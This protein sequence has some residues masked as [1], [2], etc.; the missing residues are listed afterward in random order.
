MPRCSNASVFCRISSVSRPRTREITAN[1]WGFARFAYLDSPLPSLFKER[2]F[3]YLSRFCE[4]RYCIVRHLGFLV[5]LGRPSGDEH[6]V[7]Q[8]VEEAL[9]L[10][11]RRLARGKDAEPHISRCAAVDAPLAE[12]PPPDSELEESIFTCAAHAF[13]QTPDAPQCLA[14]LKRAFGEARFEH[15]MVFLAFVRTA[16]YWTQIHPELTFEEDVEQLMSAHAALAEC[17]LKDPEADSR[18]TSQKLI[19]ELEVLL[20]ERNTADKARLAAIVDSSDDAIVSKTLEGIVT[21]WNRGAEKLFGYAAAE[22]IGKHISLIIPEDRISEEDYVIGKVRGGESVDHFETVR[23][24]KDGRSIDISLSV[25]PIRDSLGRIIG[26]SKI[27]RDITER[28]HAEQAVHEHRRQL[29]EADRL[30][31]EFMAMLAHELRNPLAA[32]AL[33]ADLLKRAKLDDPKARFAAPAIERQAKQLQRLADD[34]LDI[35]RATYGKLT[36][37]RERIDL[38]GVAKAI[39]A[40]HANGAGSAKIKVHG[41][42]AW[43]DGDPVRLQQMIGNLV[44]NALKYGGRTITIGVAS[45]GGHS[46]VCG[47]G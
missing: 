17:L 15:L 7:V 27:A 42:P 23:R 12:L 31:D 29:V 18:D 13:L 35:A 20:R 30:K 46:R 8:T 22:A 25:S 5:G 39:A 28:K 38:L 16:H 43:A 44:D 1:L 36:L 37:K 6:S 32:I 14:A 2:L 40:T 47:G 21:T 34:M 11:R 33:G 19:G 26:A 45:S 4:V 10:L 41:K 9:R 24:T 3:V